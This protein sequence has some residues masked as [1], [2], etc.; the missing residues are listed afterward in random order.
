MNTLIQDFCPHVLV[1]FLKGRL[2]ILILES[3]GM[4]I[5]DFNSW[6]L[7]VLQNGSANLHFTSRY[8][9]TYFL[10]L[11]PIHDNFKLGKVYQWI[12]KNGISLLYEFVSLI[13]REID[14][15]FFSASGQMFCFCY[16]DCVHI[17]TQVFLVD[18]LSYFNL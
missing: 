18:Y 9:S 12:G 7:I 13:S 14:F 16:N 3:W 15:L 8:G 1:Y 2:I 10:I 5:L 11:S 6:C 17:F 4:Y